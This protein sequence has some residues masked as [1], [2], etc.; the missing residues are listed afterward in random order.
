MKKGAFEGMTCTWYSG[1]DSSSKSTSDKLFYCNNKMNRL[2]EPSVQVSKTLFTLAEENDVHLQNNLQHILV[3]MYRSN[4]FFPISEDR[5][6]KDGIMSAV[7]G[8]KLG[9]Y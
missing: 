4:K 6:D 8:V 9:N 2:G 7:V 1:D 5:R 3:T